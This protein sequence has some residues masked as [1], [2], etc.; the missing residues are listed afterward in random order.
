MLEGLKINSKWSLSNMRVTA[1]VSHYA[2]IP[3]AK[4]DPRKSG[5][6]PG[7]LLTSFALG[8]PVISRI[9]IPTPFSRFLLKLVQMMQKI[10][11]KSAAIMIR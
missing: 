9:Y 3:S 7:R 1:K 5:V 4:N 8:L 11:T 10:S 6:S 2:L